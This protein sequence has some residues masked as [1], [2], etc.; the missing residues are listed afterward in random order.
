M[1][2]N[3]PISAQVTSGTVAKPSRL[4]EGCTC[5]NASI[6]SAGVI[7]KGASWVSVSGSGWAMR[8]WAI[9]PEVSWEDRPEKR[10]GF[11]VEG[12]DRGG[13]MEMGVGGTSIV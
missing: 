5:F 9:E 10:G 2:C 3:A 12:S 6:K 4:D 1:L 11:D 13:G 8:K 7:H